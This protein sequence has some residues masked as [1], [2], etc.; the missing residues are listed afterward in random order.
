MLSSTQ[1]HLDDQVFPLI[2][3]PSDFSD[4]LIF[5]ELYDSPQI[6]IIDLLEDQVSE[7]IKAN[8][9]SKSFTEA[10]LSS[11]VIQFFVERDRES[12]GN[13][14]YFPWKKALV[15]LL[16]EE[17][18]IKVR[19]QRNN[20]KITTKEQKELRKKKIGLIGLSVGRSIAVTI[21]LERGCGELRLAD[22]DTLELSNLNRIKAGVLDL[23]IEKVVLAA[24]EIF[25]IDPYLKITLYRNGV[26]EDNIDDFLSNG[27][28]LDLLIDECDSLDIK[29]LARERA[30]AKRIPVLMETSDRGMLDVERFDRE[31]S[32][33]IFHGLLGDFNFSDLKNL[34]SQQKVPVGL[35]IIGLNTISTRMKVSL[36]ELSQSISSWPQLASAVYLGGATVANASRKVLLGENV[37]SGRYYV[38]LDELVLSKSEKAKPEPTNTPNTD[39]D[40]IDLLPKNRYVSNY[41]ISHQD[42][43]F[44]IEKANTAPSGGN[45]QPWKWIFDQGGVL[46]LLH[47]KSKSE[48]LLD[49]LGTGSLLAFG[50]ALQNFRLVAASMGIEL[51]I[52]QHIQNFEEELIASIVFDSRS[53]DPISILN[54][55]LVAGISM[56]CTNRKNAERVPLEKQTLDEFKNIATSDGVSLEIID[57]L[58]QL[59]ALT[60]IVGGMD[61]LRLLHDQGYKDFI[62]EIRWS[63][64]EALETKDG[65]DIATLEMGNSERAAVGLVRD[66]GTIEFF[67]KNDL[68]YG[69][70]KISDQTILSASAVLMFTADEYTPSAFL[71]AGAAIQ[72]VWIKANLSGYSFQPISSSLFIFH[73]VLR[74]KI[75]GFSE[76]EKGM[77]QQFKNDLN[78][79]FNRGLSK[80]EVFMVRINKA[81]EPSMRAFRRDV[82][83]SLILL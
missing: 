6:T 83:A 2:F 39:K 46:H 64:E 75:T 7:L 18:F 1:F 50:A 31:P 80:Q 12:Y 29:V 17:D 67:R 28:D 69:L 15:R 14:V 78:Q 57:G 23:G 3:T 77:I 20:Y 62:S 32:R 41:K 58:E 79:I 76:N 66:P 21:A 73:R 68:G 70:T 44:I 72:R 36:L 65:I 30:K 52:H 56:R 49:Y 5:R 47:D 37:E 61:R 35:K 9:P 38:D 24:R 51:T 16:P 45:S 26:N 19:T 54:G 74:E 25:E 10:E 40:F 53:E 11:L 48:S 13:W 43:F 82:S 27:G 8:N 22:F 4:S 63:A 71:K 55:D 42:L 60:P 81:G 34:T 59:R 33:E